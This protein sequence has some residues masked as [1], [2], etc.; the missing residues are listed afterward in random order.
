MAR[1]RQRIVFLDTHIVVWLYAGQAERL[2]ETA[3][4]A[5]EDNDV[6]VSAFVDL[7]LQYLYEIGR[8]KTMPAVILKELS[9]SIGLRT[10]ETSLSSLVAAA[11][12]IHWTRD[13]FD[14]L[15]VAET[16]LHKSR[17][18]TKD[19]ELRSKFNKAIW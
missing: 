9:G 6:Y 3:R 2:S 4:K 17:L 14:R 18:I 5:I 15:L 7:E 19:T 10:A 16:T 13:V 1:S 8:I 12:K 11:K